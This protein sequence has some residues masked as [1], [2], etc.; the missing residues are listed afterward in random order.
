MNWNKIRLNLIWNI[1]QQIIE[2]LEN[3][4]IHTWN[5]SQYEIDFDDGSLPRLWDL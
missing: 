4:Y 2:N 1:F 5:W 3:W